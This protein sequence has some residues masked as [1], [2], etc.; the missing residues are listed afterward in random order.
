MIRICIFLFVIVVGCSSFDGF[1][2]QYQM[3]PTWG[4]CS[5][6]VTTLGESPFERYD[7][8]VSLDSAIQ[9]YGARRITTASDTV[10][11]EPIP[12]GQHLM[13]LRGVK[14]NCTVEGGADR[15]FLMGAGGVVFL[16]YNVYCT[17]AP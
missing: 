1:E 2:P 7:Y 8:L 16:L 3:P 15:V 9:G 14:P 12:A 17:P 10:V 4:L 11:I 6:R 5:L 13:S